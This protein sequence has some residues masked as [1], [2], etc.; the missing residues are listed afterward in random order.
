MGRFSFFFLYFIILRPPNMTLVVED[1]K[2]EGI[3]AFHSVLEENTA[4][5]LYAIFR[6]ET[7]DNAGS[8]RDKWAYFKYIGSDVGV[9]KKAKLSIIGAK[10]DAL[11]TTKH[12]TLDV[13]SDDVKTITTKDLADK[14]LKIGG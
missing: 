12:L 4:K 11:F 6:V 7:S 9:M 2:S 5:M 8:K 14:F 13:G 10:I 1:E 3:T